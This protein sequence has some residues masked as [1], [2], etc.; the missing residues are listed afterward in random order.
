MHNK[1]QT[2]AQYNLHYHSFFLLLLLITHPLLGQTGTV[3]TREYTVPTTFQD[4][5]ETADARQLGINIDS[6]QSLIRLIEDTPPS[7]L[8]GLAVS[9]NGKLIIDEYFNTYN[10]L[11][12]HDIR[13][14]TKSI[15]AMLA[16]IA[17]RDNHFSTTTPLDQLFN[18]FTIPDR[19]KS[20]ITLYHL[21]TMQSSL[22]ADAL[23]INTPGNEANWLTG[24]EDWLKTI[25]SIPMRSDKPGTRYV[26]NSANAFLVGAAVEE[27]YEMTLSAFAKK[28]LFTP[29]QIKEYYWALGP[30]SHTAGMG[31]LYLTNRDFL[32]LG[33]LVLDKGKWNEIQVIPNEWLR[34]MVKNH[35]ELPN[36]FLDTHSYGYLWYV[37]TKN[38]SGHAIDYSFASGNGGN[39]LYIVPSINLVVAIQSSAYGTGYGNFRSNVIFEKVL[40]MVE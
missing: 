14:A 24:E 35:V 15:T 29:L 25:L 4:G 33:Q 17:I 34:D 3:S 11:T 31:N 36:P 16:G 13:S 39:V 37:G 19:S 12:V 8:R 18:Q 23:D 26:Y 40:R 7:D 22:D 6:L 9:R 21:L 27:S 1:E 2:G 5:W 10:R 30:G 28:Y 38:I 32:K 20:N